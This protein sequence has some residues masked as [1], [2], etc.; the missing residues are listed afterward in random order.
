MR[1][2]SVPMLMWQE[3]WSRVLSEASGLYSGDHHLTS[4]GEVD[5][6]VYRRDAD[7]NPGLNF[8]L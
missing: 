8:S 7:C 3:G 2:D 4:V 5:E 6:Y 1:E